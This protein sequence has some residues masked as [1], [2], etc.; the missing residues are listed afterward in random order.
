[1]TTKLQ[2][3]TSSARHYIS[4]KYSNRKRLCKHLFVKVPG[5]DA[6]GQGLAKRKM[7]SASRSYAPIEIISFR[8]ALMRLGKERIGINYATAVKKCS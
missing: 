4:Q 8:F 3:V 1:M 2:K 5:K 6:G 7:V